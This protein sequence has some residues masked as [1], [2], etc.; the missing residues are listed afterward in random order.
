ML[1]EED[2]H[3]NL[4]ILIIQIQIIYKINNLKNNN[5]MDKALFNLIQ[6]KMVLI[7]F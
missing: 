1:L 4:K 5:K 2:I 6:L 7:Q 3:L